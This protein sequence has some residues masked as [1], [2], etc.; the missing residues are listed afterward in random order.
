MYKFFGRF[1]RLNPSGLLQKKEFTNNPIKPLYDFKNDV[2]ITC[3]KFSTNLLPE[4][5]NSLT[6]EQISSLT[7]G[8]PQLLQKLNMLMLEVQVLHQDGDKVPDY[9]SITFEQWEHLLS[10]RSR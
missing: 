7:K 6:D 4:Q 8:D 5:N 1:L 9:N 10:L 3:N 2:R